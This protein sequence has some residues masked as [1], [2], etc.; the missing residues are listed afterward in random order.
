MESSILHQNWIRQ[1]NQRPSSFYSF[2]TRSILSNSDENFH[3]TTSRP[4]IFSTESP[5]RTDFESN[6]SRSFASSSSTNITI[7]EFCPIN[8]EEEEEKDSSKRC[9][10]RQEKYCSSNK[11]IYSD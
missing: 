4:D 6:S 1:E 2:S 7:K 3:H 11:E 10:Y 8:E 5:F 9:V